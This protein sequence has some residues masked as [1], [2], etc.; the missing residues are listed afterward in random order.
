MATLYS[1]IEPESH[2]ICILSL[3]ALSEIPVIWQ[4]G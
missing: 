3:A 1:I 2:F 4:V